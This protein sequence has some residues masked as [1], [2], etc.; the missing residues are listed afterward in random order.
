MFYALRLRSPQLGAKLV[1]V[2]I[3]PDLAAKVPRR[4]SGYTIARDLDT[5]LP[6]VRRALR[7]LHE[8]GLV[9]CVTEPGAQTAGWYRLG[10]NALRVI[11][12]YRHPGCRDL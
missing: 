3:A 12:G 10:P 7:T 8:W 5:K 1:W 6:T 4:L 2:F 11:D 9:E